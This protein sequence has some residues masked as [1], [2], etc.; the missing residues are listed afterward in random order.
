MLIG[1]YIMGGGPLSS[2]IADRVRKKDGLSYTAMT[3]FQA[4]SEDER[5]MYMMFCIS[6]PKNTEKVVETVAEEVDRMLDSGVTGEELDKAKESFLTNRIGGRANDGNLA[7]E[8]LTNLKT[9]RTM[10]FQATSD[11]KISSLNK[12]RVDEALKRLI[13]PEKLVIVTAGDFSKSEDKED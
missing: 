3:R 7:G 5:G 12:D 11:A 9:G 13:V 8:L 6:N 1:N 2:R 10:E 4:D